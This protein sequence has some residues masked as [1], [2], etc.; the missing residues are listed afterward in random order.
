ML[1]GIGDA[2]RDRPRHP[3]FKTGAIGS[4]HRPLSDHLISYDLAR[5]L[6]IIAVIAWIAGMLML[7]RFYASITATPHGGAGAQ[8]LLLQARHIRMIIL[9]PFMIMAWAF[10]IFLFVAYFA[11]DWTDPAARLIEV[12][13]WFWMKLA[14][15][16]SLTAYHGMLVVEGR[17][18]A[19]GERRHS[20]RF[21]QILSVVP[22]FIAIVIVLLATLEP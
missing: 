3:S 17:R 11:S 4:G 14:L 18:L 22:F 16:L 13:H 10:G 8:E 9:T 20:A 2:D 15:V 7:P 5:G 1:G 12:P 19:A 21:W 6:H